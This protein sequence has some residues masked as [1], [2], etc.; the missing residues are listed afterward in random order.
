MT[1][2]VVEVE[3]EVVENEEVVKE[4]GK[5]V[6]KEIPQTTKTPFKKIADLYDEEKKR[7]I[8]SIKAGKES[9]H[10]E[11]KEFK[12]GTFRIVKRKQPTYL[13]K[14][15]ANTKSKDK[16]DPE[17]IYLANDQLMNQ[18]ISDLEIKYTKLEGKYKKQKKRVNDIYEN[19]EEDVVVQPEIQPE[20]SKDA[21]PQQQQVPPQPSRAL[22]LRALRFR[23]Y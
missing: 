6:V 4:K 21:P 20:G 15:V 19:I 11:L 14:V 23:R 22:S 3:G 16:S 1:K 7:I 13:E 9:E 5:E 10:Y 12:N 8:D 2:L 18:R 17:N